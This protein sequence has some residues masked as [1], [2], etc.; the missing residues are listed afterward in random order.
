M[1]D[2][3]PRVDLAW[4]D[5]YW[6]GYQTALDEIEQRK[7]HA[8]HLDAATFQA[9]DED[10]RAALL[11]WLRRVSDVEGIAGRTQT[12]EVHE[13]WLRLEQLLPC[14][15]PPPVDAWRR[16]TREMHG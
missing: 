14:S 16:L 11:D 9:G 1:S 13:G 10:D 7:R 2:E 4:S 12:V 8:L 5:D 6:R 15:E 3:L